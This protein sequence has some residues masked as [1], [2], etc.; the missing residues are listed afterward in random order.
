MVNKIAH[1]L[2]KIVINWNEI[3]IEIKKFEW[4]LHKKLSR[5]WK[6]ASYKNVR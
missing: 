6:I 4:K 5:R 1:E 2:N 3:L